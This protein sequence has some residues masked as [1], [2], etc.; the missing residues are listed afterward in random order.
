M[1]AGLTIS[2]NFTWG[3]SIDTVSSNAN[4]TLYGGHSTVANPFNLKAYRGLSDFD[5]PYGLAT[6][7]VWQLPSSKSNSFVLKHVLSHWTVSG[8]WMWQGGTPFSIYSGVDNSLT[9]VG[10]DYADLVPGVSPKLDPGRPHQQLTE[11]YFNVAAFQPNA[12]GTFGNSGRNILRAPGFSNVDFS[13]IKTIPL[14]TEKLHLTIRGEFFNLLN[15]PQ[16][17]APNGAGGGL[18]TPQFGRITSVRDPR[19]LQFALKLNW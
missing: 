19:I 4:G 3:K 5:V 11:K 8:I 18:T 1:A 6:S 7:F 9:G 16:F 14:R 10:M 17:G 12:T 15:T 13:V 2:S